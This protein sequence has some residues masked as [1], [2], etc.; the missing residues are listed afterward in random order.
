VFRGSSVATAAALWAA[1]L[2]GAGAAPRPEEPDWPCRQ[3]LVPKLT[4]AAYWNGPPL[5]S[6][7]DWHADP[8]VAAL[9]RRL[10]PRPVSPDEG[11]AAIAAFAHG[12]S[13]DRARRLALVFRGLLDETNRERG[14]LIGALKQMGRRQRELAGLV[15]RLAAERDAIPPD[16][17]GE[18]AARRLDLEQRHDFTVRNFE[19]IGRT[20]R[21]AC[22]T[23]V[24]LD[25][26]LGGW[27]RAL[28]AAAAQ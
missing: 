27:A 25:A 6:I 7:G 19:E 12:L 10:A 22:D 21:Y 24:G 15:S 5:D 9:V 23:P 3:H 26:R 11:L 14:A 28:Q 8:A 1:A 17:T 13:A 20:I 16:A 2:L 18:A 4:A